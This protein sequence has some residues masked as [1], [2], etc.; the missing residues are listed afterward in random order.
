MLGLID[1]QRTSQENSDHHQVNHYQRKVHNRTHSHPQKPAANYQRAYL[2]SDQAQNG[3]TGNDLAMKSFESKEQQSRL[4]LT[5]FA[6]LADSVQIQKSDGLK[7]MVRFDAN[8]VVKEAE[9]LRETINSSKSQSKTKITNITSTDIQIGK[10]PKLNR[11]TPF[12]PVYTTT[13]T[14]HSPQAVNTEIKKMK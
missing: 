5:Q 8:P 1:S 12:T 13:Q 7:H 9:T 10:V 11:Y 2:I 4:K 14:Q 3:N 6:N